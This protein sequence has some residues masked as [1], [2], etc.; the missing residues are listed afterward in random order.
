MWERLK[1]SSQGYPERMGIG[2]AVFLIVLGAILTFALDWHLAELDLAVVGWIFMIAGVVWA[3]FTIYAWNR[4][5][6]TR[7]RPVV[8]E[9]H[10]PRTVVEERDFPA[11]DRYSHTT[12]ETP[13]P[14]D[15]GR[16]EQR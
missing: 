4:R 6:A 14:G 8:E 12:V 1:P 15:R 7:T 10:Y 5:R 9:H 2:A 11:T 13:P 16:P 3:G